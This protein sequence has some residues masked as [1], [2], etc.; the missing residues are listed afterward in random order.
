MNQCVGKNPKPRAFTL[1]ELLVVIGIIGV[2]MAILLPA[3]G[4]ARV[5]SAIWDL[6]LTDSL[7]FWTPPGSAS[8]RFCRLARQGT[9]TRR[10]SASR[11][12][13]AIHC[14]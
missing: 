13:P 5:A 4:R 2:L 10:T 8:G 1:V 3:L 14:S 11:R 9:A 6:T 12:W 7:I